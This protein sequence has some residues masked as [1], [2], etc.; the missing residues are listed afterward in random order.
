[1]KT[2]LYVLTMVLG[3]VLTVHLAMNGKV[4]AVSLTNVL[5]AVV[6]LAGVFLATRS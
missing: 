1:M 6:M 2:Y 4:G 3:V 5:G